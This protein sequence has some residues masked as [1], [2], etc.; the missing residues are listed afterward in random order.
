MSDPRQDKFLQSKCREILQGNQGTLEHLINEIVTESATARVEGD[1][2][3]DYA[4]Q[5]IRTQGMKEGLTLLLKK[6]N[7]YADKPL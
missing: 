3:F 5:T 1:T 2:A 4:K 7:K 6:I